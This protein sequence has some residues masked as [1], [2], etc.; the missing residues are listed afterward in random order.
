[1]SSPEFDHVDDELLAAWASGEVGEDADV[2]AHLESCGR[3]TAEVVA[4][5]EVVELVREAR[6]EELLAPP[7]SVW[8]AVRAEVDGSPATSGATVRPIRRFAKVPTW[9]AATAAAVALAAGVGVGTSLGGADDEAP[10]PQPQVLA[11]T[12]LASL[13]DEALERGVAEVRRHE[14]RVVLHVE[15]SELGGPQGTREVWLINVDGSRMV[16]LGLLPAGE[17][18]EFDFPE[19]LLDEGYRV[20]DISYEPDDGDPTHSGESLARGTIEG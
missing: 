11:S 8:E 10:A 9:L 5:R 18:G 15:A 13:D 12:T 4:L 17:V 2:R 3:C 7:P 6:H 16:S 1:M 14:E 19:R 20:V